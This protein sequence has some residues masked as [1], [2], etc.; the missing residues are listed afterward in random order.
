MFQFQ[1]LE[2][3]DNAAVLDCL[4]FLQQGPAYFHEA[5]ARMA[6]A[7]DRSAHLYEDADGRALLHREQDNWENGE[8]I[9]FDLL[10]TAVLSS[11][12]LVLPDNY[13]FENVLKKK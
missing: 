6:C 12:G 11:Y 3:A 10:R 4:E 9:S 2:L 13:G 8:R 1:A 5:M 7:H